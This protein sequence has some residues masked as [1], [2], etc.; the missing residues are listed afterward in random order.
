MLPLSPRPLLRSRRPQ[1][2]MI[3]HRRGHPRLT[4]KTFKSTATLAHAGS[5]CIG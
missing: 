4:A 3:E 1:P 5:W 2:S